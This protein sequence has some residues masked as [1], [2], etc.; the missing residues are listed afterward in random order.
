[1]T[2]FLGLYQENSSVNGFLLKEIEH[3]TQNSSE[4]DSSS[5]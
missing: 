5:F 3:P 1:M 4:Q 2:P